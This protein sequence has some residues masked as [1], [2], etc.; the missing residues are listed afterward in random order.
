MS[1]AMRGTRRGKSGNSVPE[2][3]DEAGPLF[4]Q[5]PAPGG[6]KE[7]G[8]ACAGP[9]GILGENIQQRTQAI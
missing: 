6:Q 2:K 5:F 9:S 3:T 8:P 1:D 4:A 7:K